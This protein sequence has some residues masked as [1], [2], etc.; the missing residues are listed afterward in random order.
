MGTLA[1][2]FARLRGAR[3]SRSPPG[4]TASPSYSVWAR[5][6]RGRQSEDIGG[7]SRGFAP[8]GVDAVLAFAGGPPLT[9]CLDAL[10]T[11]GRIAYPNGVEPPPSKRR[12]LRMTPTTP[13]P[14]SPS[15]QRLTRAVEAAKLKVPI[16]SAYSLAKAAEAHRRLARGHVLGKIVLRI[17]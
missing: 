3:S 5:P 17:R 13:I 12:G 7:R 16:D 8:D 15:S 9:R 11:G 4:A 6:G 1:V 14:G 2:Q 10:R